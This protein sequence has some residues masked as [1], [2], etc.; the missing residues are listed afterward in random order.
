MKQIIRKQTFET[1]SSSTHS[2]TYSRT[3]SKIYSLV[4][5]ARDLLRDIT[6]DC[7]IYEA[8]AK[9]QTASKLIIDE[10][11]SGDYKKP[12]NSDYDD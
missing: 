5:D 4:D 3:F 7:E 2:F 10:L 9:L 6:N 1:N 11:G 8:L 12:Q